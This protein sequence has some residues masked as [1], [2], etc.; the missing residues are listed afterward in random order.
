MFTVGNVLRQ[1]I[2]DEPEMT[3]RHV[4]EIVAAI[5]PFDET[6]RSHQ[7]ETL[8]WLHSTDD[9]Y[10]RAKPATPSPHLVAY[11]V[12]ADPSDPHMARFLAKVR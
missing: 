10:R 7:S 12:L 11:A 6:E 4:A 3:I 1:T 8:A 2:Y 9:I 5:E